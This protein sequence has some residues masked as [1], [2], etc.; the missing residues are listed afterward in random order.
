MGKNAIEQHF[1]GTTGSLQSTT[2]RRCNYSA[3]NLYKVR[4]ASIPTQIWEKLRALTAAEGGTVSFLQVRGLR[5]VAPVDGP[6]SMHILEELRTFSRLKKDMELEGRRNKD[7]W[8]KL[9]VKWNMI[10]D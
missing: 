3:Q 10:Y 8:V 9:G 1:L 4:P 7:I 6:I 2:Y 5:W